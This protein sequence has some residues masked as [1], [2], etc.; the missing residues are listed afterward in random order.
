MWDSGM[1]AAEA[2]DSTESAAMALE[3]SMFAKVE[4]ESCRF[5]RRVC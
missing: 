2:S 3:I 4:V 5:E 1:T